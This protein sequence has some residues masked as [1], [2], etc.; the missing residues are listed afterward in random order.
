LLDLLSLVWGIP[1]LAALLYV[2]G[3]VVLNVMAARYPYNAAFSGRDE[4]LFAALLISALVTGLTVFVL[5]ELGLFSWWLVLLL[6]LG[7]AL[8]VALVWGRARKWRDLLGLLKLPP[9]PPMRVTDRREARARVIV[10]AVIMLVAA[11]LYSR[12]AEMLRGALDAGVYV[13]SGIAMGRSGS[14]L[15]S[16]ILLRQLN[17]DAGEGRE[18]MQPFNPDR[19]TF[20]RLRMPGFYEFDKKAALV[21]P[22][23]YSLFPAWIGLMY[24]LFGV[25][26]ALYVQ[27]LLALIS[28]LAFYFFARRVL[29]PW[30]SLL[31][32][33]LLA[34]CPVSIWFARYPVSEVLTLFLAFS[35]F[36]A[37][38]RMVSLATRT[39]DEGRRTEDDEG[40]RTED[41][42]GR[43]TK[44]EE[45]ISEQ[46][47]PTTTHTD[48]HS[49]FVLRPSSFSAYAKLWGVVAGG[50][51][52]LMALARPDFALFLVPLVPYV[53][54]W[55][56]ARRWQP[57]YTWMLVTLGGLLALYAVHFFFFTYGYTVDLY[58]NVIL[59]TRRRWTL[60]LGL[61]YVGIIVLVLAD[62]FYPRLRPAWA[63]VEN[64]AVRWRWVW[65]GLLVLFVGGYA[66]FHYLVAPWL[67]NLRFDK[68]GNPIAQAI[69]T[70]WDSYIGSFT[71]E[72]GRYNLVRIGWYLSP[73]GVVLGVGGLLR[74][75]WGR[76]D[77]ASGLFFGSLLM[78][79]FVFLP[80][81][82]TDAHYIYSMR[83][84]LPII[85]PALIL[86]IAWACHFLWTRVRPS[87]L[88][89]TL[90]GAAALGM[91]AFFI[92]T[93][94]RVI[95][96]HVE[97]EGAV[98][99]FTELAKRFPEKSVVLFSDGRDEPFI[100]ATPLHHTFGID[101]WV[102]NRPYPQIRND[103]LDGIVKRWESQGYKVWVMMGAN[104]GKLDLP[105][106]SLKEEGYWEYAV[107]EFEQLYTQKPYN[108]YQTN[109]PWGIYSL[110][111]KVEPSPGPVSINVG[112]MDYPY[113]VEGFYTEET[114]EGDKGKWRWTGPAALMRVPWPQSNEDTY[115]GATLTLRARQESPSDEGLVRPQEPLTLKVYLDDTPVGEVVVRPGS[116]FEDYELTVPAGVPRKTQG[117]GSA[118]LRIDSPTWSPKEAGV[119][120]DERVLGVQLDGVGV[121]L[122][123][124]TP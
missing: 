112:D 76:L 23:H 49:S 28:L 2:L 83:R 103:V 114:A 64:A 81:T 58:F 57:A 36:L 25:W 12:P 6:V 10:L 77:A 115:A 84:Y 8:I 66:V 33:A 19:Y 94:Y 124:E 91:L 92:Y 22:Q 75:I 59:E 108:T 61:L 101:S 78:M 113:L 62:R 82:Y 65:A 109:L 50:C 30:S 21:L 15:Q 96:P 118:L 48:D 85:L 53:A 104:G 43:R 60:L 3:A 44:D 72:G 11:A 32:L 42:E 1:V 55:R 18:L 26:G 9:P 98:G 63:W 70:T 56:L 31:A 110:Q 86:G 34:F 46:A 107:P 116:E 73:L 47:E 99:Q 38:H 51:L 29:S 123:E 122:G 90:A 40:R 74:W 35:G 105:S 111:P 13:N 4:W 39:K 106:Y 54:Y 102:V 100:V 27:P 7:L 24:T 67:E 45:A 14:I 68:A 93:S 20:Q 95:I 80:E 16:D 79:G 5:A 17:D 119:G 69:P 89:W 37:F 120:S 52:G 88:G 71:D 117:T 121:G 41:D 97:Y 87:V